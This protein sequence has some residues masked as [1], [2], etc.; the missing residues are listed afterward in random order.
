[1][2]IT[3]AMKRTKDGW[4]GATIIDGKFHSASTTLNPEAALG[5][6]AN[7]LLNPLGPETTILTDITVEGAADESGNAQKGTG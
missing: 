7:L 5:R 3:L 2:K 1:M 6:I 4:E